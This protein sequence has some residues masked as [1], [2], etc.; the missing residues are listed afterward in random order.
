MAI[1][2]ISLRRL[3]L[4]TETALRQTVRRAQLIEVVSHMSLG[5]SWLGLE[6]L[7]QLT[8][9]HPYG[10][11]VVMGDYDGQNYHAVYGTIEVN[12]FIENS[13]FHS[14]FFSTINSAIWFGL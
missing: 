12:Y 1:L 11:K 7:N 2:L 8:S 14:L 6:Q 3:L 13:T 4:S 9:Q 5:E 10:L